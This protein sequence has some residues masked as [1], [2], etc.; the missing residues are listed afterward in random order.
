M[1]HALPEPETAWLGAFFAAPN[2]LGWEAIVDGSAPADVIE[3][4]RLW[5]QPLL[6]GE[7][8]VPIILPF[9]RTVPHAVTGWYATTPGPRGGYELGEEL[10][11]WLGPTYLNVFEL[12]PAGGKD[13]MAGA[14]RARFSGTVYRFAGSDAAAN[15]R[16]AARVADYG[17]LLRRRPAI[18]RRSTRPVGSIRADFERALLARDETRAEELIVELRE[19]GRL[20]EEN[21]RYLDIRLKAGLGLWPQVARDHWLIL[22]MSDLALPP[23]TLADIIEALFRTYVDEVE[24][25]GDFAATRQAFDQ[26]IAKRYPRLFASRRGIRIPHVVK[27]FLLYELL[28]PRPNPQI[29]GDLV[30]LLPEREHGSV[31]MQAAVSAA[32]A[33]T[34]PATSEANADEA[35]DD[36]QYDRAFE[37][38][39][40]LPLSRRSITRLLSC[41]LFIGTEEATRR[42]RA[43]VDGAD[44]ELIAT[45]PPPV[46]Q[47]IS[48]LRTSTPD[49]S[50]T[51]DVNSASSPWTRW[52][53]QLKRGTDP[54]DA[55]RSVQ[56]AATSWDIAPFQESQHLS[57]AFADT[58]G[59]LSGEAEAVVRRSVPQIFAAFFPSAAQT[60]PGVKPIAAVLFVLI[61]MG[62]SL[63]RTDLD[64]LAQLLNSL[65]SFGLSADDY[66][67]VIADLEDV[68]SRVGSYTHLPWSLDVCEALAVAPCPS[69][70]G[71]NARLQLF[72][73]V[74]GQAQAFAHRLGPQD[75]LPIEFV[76]KDYGISHEAIVSLKRVSDEDTSRPTLPTLDGKTLGIYT[77]EEAAGSRAKQALEM[78]FPGCRVEVNS[79]LVCTAKLTSLARAADLFVFAWKSSSHQAF[80]CVK[81][82]SPSEPVWALGKGTASILRAVLDNLE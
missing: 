12:V 50:E 8:N 27:A 72:L 34:A 61:A 23:Q 56:A 71:H 80:Y 70:A 25:T 17:A 10:Q 29:I 31:L 54:A 20:N 30:A 51:S 19:T 53:E 16:I 48:D 78:M 38:Y 22:T 5:L 47:R 69:D 33:S 49:V 57:K 11:A 2:A 9:A 55:E 63:S 44:S 74:L 73:K 18:L 45:L 75:L 66:V 81:G 13:P 6:K 1:I 62:E 43:A 68:Q 39:L 79:D 32:N 26:H 77:L 52:A 24:A 46:Q 67:S 21:L 3:Q 28:Q 82:A 60:A 65:L 7:S 35:F 40:A 42:L 41:V 64:L 15:G 59:N 14:M 37:L 58:L 36:A 4:I 76:A